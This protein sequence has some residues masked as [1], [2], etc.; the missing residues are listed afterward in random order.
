LQLS[1]IKWAAI[2]A[3]LL[4]DAVAANEPSNAKPLN[5]L[6]RVIVFAVEQETKANH[7]DTRRDLCVGFGNGLGADEKQILRELKR[8]GLK[9]HRGDWCNRRA[10]GFVVSVATP[11]TQ[12]SAARYELTIALVD[13]SPLQRGE[14]LALLLHRGTYVVQCDESSEPQLI[15]YRSLDDQK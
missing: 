10:R 5:A 11:V 12:S 8:N 1:S 7:L 9:I 4:V 15:T 13:L 14:D 3:L 6:E 2:V